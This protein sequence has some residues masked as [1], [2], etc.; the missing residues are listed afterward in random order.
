MD[1]QYSQNFDH[2]FSPVIIVNNDFEVEYF[3]PMVSTLLQLPPRKITGVSV[4]ELIPIEES[5]WDDLKKAASEGSVSVSNELDFS[6]LGNDLS[7]VFR[8]TKH[9]SEFI[10]FGNDLS[11]EKK[12][13]QKYREQV[14]Q[15]KLGHQEVL[16]ADKV[17]AVG[18][19]T[20]GIS[21]E[22]NNPLTVATGNTEILGFML[23]NDDLNSER[24][25]IQNCITNIDESLVRI[26]EIILG[27]KKFLHET[28]HDKKE[29]I[30]LDGVVETSEK[31]VTSTFSENKV[32][33]KI[34]NKVENAVVLGNKTRLEQVLI[35]LLK[36]ALDS[37]VTARTENPVVELLIEKEKSGNYINLVVIDNGPGVEEENKEKIFEN[38]FTT[39]EMGEGTGLGLS[40]CRKIAEDHQGSLDLTTPEKGA[41]FTLSLPVIE[42]SSYASNDEI[43]SKI[44]HVD[45]KKVLVVDNDAT[46]LNLCQKFLDSTPYIFIG[47]TGGVEAL[48]VLDKYAIDAVITDL[49][50]PGLDGRTFVSKLREKSSDLPVFYLSS[51]KGME[52][53]Q[54]DKDQLNLSGIL[55]K[56]FKSE[57]LINLLKSTF[58]KEG[59]DE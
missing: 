46:I 17:R 30:N 22:I 20:A 9:E 40:L 38:F 54:K 19:L 32:T 11:V 48:E 28:G 16:K 35:N 36:N 8:M 58:S 27:M 18:E 59:K 41:Q 55:L 47:S 53:Y 6:Y 42:V 34:S 14:E 15:L 25:G 7:F 10:I 5:I 13:H 31:L 50:M 4:K 23:E 44:N 24:E 43:L 33:L 26:N 2:S 3:N 39:K 37:V 12:L 51:S 45:G 29:Y 21:H 56:P 52:T 49:Q 1:K 57:E